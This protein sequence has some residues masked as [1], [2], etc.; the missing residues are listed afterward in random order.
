MLIYLEGLTEVTAGVNLESLL[1]GALL[2]SFV[3]IL[4]GLIKVL[5][6]DYGMGKCLGEHF[7]I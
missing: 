5:Y 2:G 1:L 4:L 3:V 6:E 7:G